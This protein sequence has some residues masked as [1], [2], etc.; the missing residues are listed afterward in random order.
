LVLGLTTI[1]RF[2]LPPVLGVAKILYATA[3]TPIPPF[4]VPGSPSSFAG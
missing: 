1:E 2:G 4:I 3:F